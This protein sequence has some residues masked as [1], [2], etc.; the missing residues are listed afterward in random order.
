M[1][2]RSNVDFVGIVDDDIGDDAER[3]VGFHHQYDV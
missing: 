2:S 3:R 1:L